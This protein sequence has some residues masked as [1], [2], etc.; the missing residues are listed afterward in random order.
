[1]FFPVM[2]LPGACLGRKEGW[3][4]AGSYLGLFRVSRVIHTPDL[5]RRKENTVADP[6]SYVEDTGASV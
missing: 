6:H 4:L 2:A 1:M 3:R 5:D